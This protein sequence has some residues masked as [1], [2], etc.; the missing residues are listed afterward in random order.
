MVLIGFPH[1]V[2]RDAVIHYRIEREVE[3]TLA[4]YG[5]HGREIHREAPVKTWMQWATVGVADSGGGAGGPDGWHAARGG[6]RAGQRGHPMGA[7]GPSA[8]ADATAA[9][10][11]GFTK[12]GAAQT[13][14]LMGIPSPLFTEEEFTDRFN[15]PEDFAASVIGD[16][17]DLVF[18]PVDPRASAPMAA[19]SVPAN[20][21]ADRAGG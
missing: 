15:A 21:R 11:R 10:K 5:E 3:T 17:R 16:R 18:A 20:L 14:A 12:E 9:G 13:L 7:S 19:A 8:G 4:G 6:P 2:R 1:S